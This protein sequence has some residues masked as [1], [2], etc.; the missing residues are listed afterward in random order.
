MRTTNTQFFNREQALHELDGLRFAVESLVQT[1]GKPGS[2]EREMG[3]NAARGIK[4]RIDYLHD[5]FG[6]LLGL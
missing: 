1:L 6:R 4:S 5:S 2:Y 3:G